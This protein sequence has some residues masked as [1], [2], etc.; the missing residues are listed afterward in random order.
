MRGATMP[1]LTAWGLRHERDI[2]VGTVWL[3]VVTLAVLAVVKLATW[4]VIRRQHDR[5]DVGRALKWQKL[6]EVV[7]YVALGLAYAAA[8]TIYYDWIEVS[9]WWR[10]GL[11]IV[12]GLAMVVAVVFGVRFAVALRAE[13][14]GAPEDRP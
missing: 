10:Y 11:R 3:L 1:D 2:E 4:A 6:S 13:R 7:L 9:L 5:T 12:A 8:L 14:W